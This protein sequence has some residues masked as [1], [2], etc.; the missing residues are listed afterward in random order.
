MA[1]KSLSGS[2]LPFPS[3]PF[4]L[5]RGRYCSFPLEDLGYKGISVVTRCRLSVKEHERYDVSMRQ[6]DGVFCYSL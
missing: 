1:G 2:S 4:L 5:G 6:R 3:L